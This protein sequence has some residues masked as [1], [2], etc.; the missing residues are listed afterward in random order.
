MATA[1]LH[2]PLRSDQAEPVSVATAQHAERRV[3][4][5]PERAGSTPGPEKTALLAAINAAPRRSR[6]RLDAFRRM[7]GRLEELRGE[8]VQR[9]TDAREQVEAAR[10]H[11]RETPIAARRDWAFPLYPTAMID[12]LARA[13]GGQVNQPEIR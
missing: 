10:R 9:L 5:D 4:H 1:S 12:E 11:A 2:L 7:H 8:Q 13:V 6:D 3:W